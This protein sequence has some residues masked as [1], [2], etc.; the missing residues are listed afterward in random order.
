MRK[1]KEGDTVEVKDLM[2]SVS[3]VESDGAADKNVR[4]KKTP[5]V[6]GWFTNKDGAKLFVMVPLESIKVVEGL[7]IPERI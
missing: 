3:S 4:N 2:F 7:K 1:I 6:S 5:F